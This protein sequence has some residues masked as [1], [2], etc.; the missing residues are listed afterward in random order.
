MLHRKL[1]E[2]ALEKLEGERAGYF[3]KVLTRL[4]ED[5][6]VDVAPNLVYVML[7]EIIPLCPTYLPVR[8]LVDRLLEFVAV[9][10]VRLNKALFDP[11]YV[12]GSA[13]VPEMGKIGAEFINQILTA[14]FMKFQNG[15][16][17]TG[18]PKVL[19]YSSDDDPDEFPYRDDDE[20]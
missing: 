14:T 13:K 18:E 11:T 1:I 12:D 5:P 15:E 6:R 16:I 9:N 8:E 7:K 20:D 10:Q 2:P 3:A 4:D 17:D 19:R